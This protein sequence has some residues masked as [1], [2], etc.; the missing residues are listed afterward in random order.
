MRRVRGI[1]AVVAGVA[2]LVGGAV[3][4][5]ADRVPPPGALMTDQPIDDV[6]RVGDR[7]YL[8]GEFRRVGAYSGSGLAIDPASGAVD[9]TSAI[10]DGEVSDVVDDGAG[11]WFVGGDFDS[12]G[13][14][15]QANLVHVLASGLVD[16]SFV[17]RVNGYVAALVRRGTTLFVGGDFTA[18]NGVVRRGLAAFATTTGGALPFNARLTG[19]TTELAL[20]PAGGAHGDVL[21]AGGD[22]VHALDPTTGGPLPG[23]RAPKWDDDVS[24]LAVDEHALYVGHQGLD[25]LDPLTGAR[26]PTFAPQPVLPGLGFRPADVDALAL[27]GGKL[28]AGGDFDFIG[29]V[30][31]RSLARL[32]PVTGLADGSFRPQVTGTV[33]DLA[34]VGG[35]LWVGGDLA[36]AG[37]SAA[38]GLA[39][40]DGKGARVGVGAPVLDGP[41]YAIAAGG[42]RV[43]VGGAFHMA[44]GLSRKALV[45]VSAVSG[46]VDPTFDPPRL[47]APGETLTPAAGRLFLAP[48]QFVGYMTGR[49]YRG[50]RFT[51][52][53]TRIGVVDG[54]T[55]R[56]VSLPQLAS[57]H[58]LTGFAASGDEVFIARRLQDRLRF[59][60]NVIDVR[61]ARSGRLLRRLRVPLKGYVSRILPSG[62]RLYV[63]GS[64]RRRRANGQRAN[65]AL[66][67]LDRR[68]GRLFS[69]FDPHANGAI[70]GMT[71][72]PGK[73]YVS[74]LFD[75]V[76]G[77]VNR[78]L[79]ALDAPHGD[80]STFSA[81][82]IDA[83]ER[84]TLR[85]LPDDLFVGNGYGYDNRSFRS[86][87][88]G[89]QD[90]LVG[91][92]LGFEADAVTAL[93]NGLG[94]AGTM[95]TMVD[96]QDYGSLSFYTRTSR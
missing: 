88:D 8:S 5:V 80:L 45:A 68:T 82:D 33:Y 75:R 96:G 67:A 93:P 61:D 10:I 58:D 48:T 76:G 77:G 37:G 46:V 3:P 85:V 25:A 41:A 94:V 35:R 27:V 74:G 56:P 16:P 53:T 91:G 4:A 34:A 12:A 79:V 84:T 19:P 81:S 13:G 9:H 64:F 90:P 55:G 22:R 44:N 29:G 65:L 60:A 54:A 57:V 63:A 31:G 78:G 62:R 23:F 83:D 7:V 28:L 69:S 39:V 32:D 40:L 50:H 38:A 21:Y 18:A 95:S 30:A 87:P 47:V 2:A 42:G 11:G 73:L 14:L 6:A 89:G 17:P 15:D 26:L 59:P 24:A 20:L 86:L 70:Y 71:A 66:L 49:G 92:G 1:V 72:G 51:P 52:T 36:R 43:Y